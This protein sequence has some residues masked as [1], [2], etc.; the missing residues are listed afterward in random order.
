MHT[1]TYRQQGGDFTRGDG[2]GGKSI[3]GERFADENFKFKHTKGGLLSMA[4]AGKDTNGSQVV[5]CRDSFAAFDSSQFFITT[6]PTP[7]LD[8]KHVRQQL[9]SVSPKTEI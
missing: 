3:Y 7:W 4:N 6:V 9:S 2:T 1:F 8:G 5:M